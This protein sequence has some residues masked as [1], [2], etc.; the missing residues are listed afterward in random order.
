MS[1]RHVTV[2]FALL[3]AAFFSSLTSAAG[4][5]AG[6]L[7]VH[8]RDLVAASPRG[9]EH[10][11]LVGDGWFRVAPGRT[12]T[13]A[14][15]SAWTARL[16]RDAR[17]DRVLAATHE[18][19]AMVP[20]DTLYANDQWWLHANQ[21]GSAGVPDLPSAWD[22]S[23]GVGTN[24]PVVAV[25]DSGYTPHPELDAK[26]LL[27]GY[28]FVS[29]PQYAGDGNGWDA[30]PRDEGDQLTSAQAAADPAAW[31]GCETRDRSSWHGTLMAGQIG[32]VSNNGN[33]VAAVH[34]GLD[35]KLLPVRVAGKCGAAVS[36]VAAAM[37]WAAGLSVAGVPQNTNPARVIVLGVAGFS[38]C[39]AND[40][41]P[42][43]A[44][45]AQ[46]YVDTVRAVRAA[47]AVVIAAAG[48][49]RSAVGRPA[50]CAGVLA[51]TAL[52]RQGFKAIY[53]NFGPRIAL[54]TVGGD[55]ANGRD[56]DDLLADTG[57]TTTGNQGSAG[58]GAFGY[59]AGSGTSFAA[60]VVAGVAALM[61]SVNPALTPDDVEQG[62]RRSARPH[63]AVPLL[64]VCSSALGA[65][66]GRCQC[67]TATCGAG[68]LDA[69]QAL[70]FAAN[71]SGW[72]APSHAPVTLETPAIRRCAERLGFVAPAPV[73]ASAPATPTNGGG[74]GAFGLVWLAALGC[75]L[76]ALSRAPRST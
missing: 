11:T 13:P 70:A 49:E 18:H 48:N 7:V 39:D 37:R 43:V 46:L 42:N 27:P 22:R 51:V 59:A 15:A 73:P 58:I 72:T 25:L 2:G 75:A 1:V 41:D 32:A 17:F 55:A 8:L 76:L 50:S 38:S 36:D 57:L 66:A 20:N 16:R 63:V 54:A 34:W 64:Q 24:A 47:G 71:P 52:N 28:D 19:L 5:Q 31:D 4:P 45:A 14:Q 30:D 35:A 56:C 44:A 62:L 60:P 10:W 61:W 12:L 67:D 3:A 65:N 26:W 33:G 21:A 69:D 68:I 29:N 74:G 23:N 9:S 53:A 6:D 40:P